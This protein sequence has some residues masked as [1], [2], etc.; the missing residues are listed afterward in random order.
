[1]HLDTAIFSDIVLSG[2]AYINISEKLNKFVQGR[3]LVSALTLANNYRVY[4]ELIKY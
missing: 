2:M 1:M 4:R 3:A